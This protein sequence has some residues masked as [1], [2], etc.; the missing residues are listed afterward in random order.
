MILGALIDAGVPLGDVRAA[1]GSLAISSDSVWTERVTRAGVSAT[2]F[3]VRDEPPPRDHA[4]DHEG[5]DHHHHHPPS[6]T[7]AHE[8]R[9]HAA[10]RS[11]AAISA[12]IDGSALSAPGKTRAKELFQTLGAAE[13]A[14]H[15]T[16]MDKVHLHEVGALDS[17]IDIVG[18]V[19]A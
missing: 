16:S 5:H 17:I 9:H 3:H 1:L 7:H 12:L 11:P 15:G 19:F 2:K 4:H 13:A 14:I 18:T 6:Q 10:P 8:E